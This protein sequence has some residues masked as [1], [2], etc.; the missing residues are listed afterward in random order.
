VKVALRTL[1]RRS[2]AVQEHGLV[3]ATRKGTAF[4][5]TNLLLREIKPAAHKIGLPW[6]SW[7]TLRRTH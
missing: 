7:H 4:S 5:D 6:V 1:A 3:F 2:S